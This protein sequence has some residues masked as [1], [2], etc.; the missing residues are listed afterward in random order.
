M[1]D[2]ENTDI[3]LVSRVG[4]CNI[5]NIAKKK[6]QP[7][8][9]TLQLIKIAFMPTYHQDSLDDEYEYHDESSQ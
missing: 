2:S 8:F 4:L 6:K 7:K 3:I 5:P 1:L 9:C